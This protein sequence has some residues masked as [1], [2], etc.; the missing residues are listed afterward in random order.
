MEEKFR[1]MGLLSESDDWSE[2]PDVLA[3]ISQKEYVEGQEWRA[4]IWNQFFPPKKHSEICR[5]QSFIKKK[6]FLMISHSQQHG[7]SICR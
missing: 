6:H 1:R 3:D 7:E 4:E 5:N 2:D